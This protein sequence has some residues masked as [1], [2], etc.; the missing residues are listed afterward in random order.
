MREIE[1]RRDQDQK[2]R[3]GRIERVSERGRER[4]VKESKGAL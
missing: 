1:G 4:G 2:R 3:E